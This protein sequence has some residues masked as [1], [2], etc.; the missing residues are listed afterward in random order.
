WANQLTGEVDRGGSEEGEHV[1][2]TSSGC[3][4]LALESG[5]AAESGRHTDVTTYQEVL[6]AN[7]RPSGIY[8]KLV[9]V[10][11]VVVVKTNS[12]YLFIM[13][14]ISLLLLLL[15]TMSCV[16]PYE[17]IQPDS[18]SVRPD[19]TLTIDCKVSYSI[20]SYAT[21]WIRQPAGKGLEWIATMGYSGGLYFKDSIKNKL[22]LS[23]DTSS[24]TVTLRGQNLQTGDTAVYYCARETQ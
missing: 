1:G 24:N 21:V 23:R 9:L 20:S 4:L 14:Y 10:V 22:S 15:A 19:Q 3:A 7:I 12:V 18:L 5:G 2:V 8:L 13:F 6:Y 11:L 16:H 17:L